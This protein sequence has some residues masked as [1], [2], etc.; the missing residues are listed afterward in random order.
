MSESI[1]IYPTIVSAKNGASVN[2]G[3]VVLGQD[4]AE[5]G[6]PGILLSNREIPMAGFN[7]NFLNQA[8]NS[9]FIIKSAATTAVLGINIATPLMPVD[10]RSAATNIFG[11]IHGTSTTYSTITAASQIVTGSGVDNLTLVKALVNAGGPTLNFFKTRN[12][13]AGTSTAIVALD[14][15]GVI[16]FS[17]VA[18]NNVN[19]QSCQITAY[20]GVVNATTIDTLL[21]FDTTAGGVRTTRF[22]IDYN[23][24]ICVNTGLIA[25][26]SAIMD[27]V[28]TTKGFL[29]PRM[30]TTQKNAIATPAAGLI[31]YDTTLNKLCVY[32]TAWET[33]TSV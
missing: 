21:T 28:S 15:M 2:T 11:V 6:N 10:I 19:N 3:S 13:E 12:L 29:P 16:N 26:A 17:G 23:G 8:G 18:T 4:V 14:R 22:Q 24:S 7:L 5:A 9:A 20:A 25:N 31:V 1:I 30:T 33:I 27:I 32:T